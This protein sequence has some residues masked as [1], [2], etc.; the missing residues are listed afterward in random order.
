[1][2][3]IAGWVAHCVHPLV[4]VLE[5]RCVV[6]ELVEETENGVWVGLGAHATIIGADGRVGHLDITIVRGR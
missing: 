5:G 4:E 1:M 3:T 2:Q 6:E